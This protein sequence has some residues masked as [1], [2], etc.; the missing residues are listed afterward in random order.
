MN[1]CKYT[2]IQIYKLCIHIYIYVKVR[3][4]S[5]EYTYTIINL[6]QLN[7]ANLNRIPNV[8]LIYQQVV[9][10]RLTCFSWLL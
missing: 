8:T 10:N 1:T 3:V 5:F 7:D 4:L 9:I 6:Y 2:N